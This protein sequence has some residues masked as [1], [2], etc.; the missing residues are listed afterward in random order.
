MRRRMLSKNFSQMS[1]LDQKIAKQLAA[2]CR[3]RCVEVILLLFCFGLL[4]LV[5]VN[6]MTLCK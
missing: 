6:Q 2:E 1:N 4:L 5:A 3:L